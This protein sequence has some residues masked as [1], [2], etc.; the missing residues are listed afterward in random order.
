MAIN[1]GMVSAS[2]GTGAFGFQLMAEGSPELEV[3][4]AEDGEVLR[5][6]VRYLIQSWWGHCKLVGWRIKLV[7]A[8]WKQIKPK[9]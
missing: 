7:Q 3:T 2:A 8:S 5:K 1:A 9:T 6:S 4:V